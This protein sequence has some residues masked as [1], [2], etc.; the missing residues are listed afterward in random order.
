MKYLLIIFASLIAPSCTLL[1][2]NHEKNNCPVLSDSERD[3]MLSNE[4]NK[5]RNLPPENPDYRNYNNRSTFP[6]EYRCYL[7]NSEVDSIYVN[8]IISYFCKIALDDYKEYGKWH[9]P[10]MKPGCDY[11]AYFRKIGGNTQGEI[12]LALDVFY[13]AM[14]SQK[15]YRYSNITDSLL[16]EVDRKCNDSEFFKD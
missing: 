15:K 4:L 12:F 10:N 5:E 6:I 2:I 11:L 3:K 1:N 7:S 9:H 13:Y 14:L 16:R 8:H